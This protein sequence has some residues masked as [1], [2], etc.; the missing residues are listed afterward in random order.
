MLCVGYA[1]ILFYILYENVQGQNDQLFNELQNE[2][3]LMSKNPS[4]DQFCS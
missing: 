4:N 3:S 1:S 2:V